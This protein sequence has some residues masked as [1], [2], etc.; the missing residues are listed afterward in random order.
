GMYIA[1]KFSP[2]YI[3]GDENNMITTEPKRQNGPVGNDPESM[4]LSSVA[5]MIVVILS[6][7]AREFFAQLFLY[8]EGPFR[9]FQ[10]WHVFISD[11]PLFFFALLCA[12]GVRKAASMQR[13]KNTNPLSFIISEP[14]VKESSRITLFVLELL[15]ITA[16]AGMDLRSAGHNMGIF[17]VFMIGGMIWTVTVLLIFA[18]RMLPD[19]YWFEL[20]II[21]YGM[22]TGITALGLMLLRSIP[23]GKKSKAIM[24]YGMAAPLSAPF[25]GGGIITFLLPELTFRGFIAVEL[26]GI[27]AAM[28]LIFAVTRYIK[29]RI[30]S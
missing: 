24:V 21:N 10:K 30:R 15:I 5:L 29:R 27:L 7:L 4:V 22:S 2:K 12:L 23:G 20:G 26:L 3:T 6:A 16:I 28:G 9:I 19:S 13:E 1:G 11:L 25:I 8:L 18:K 17:A 14:V